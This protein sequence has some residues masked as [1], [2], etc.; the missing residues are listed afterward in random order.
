M[1]GISTRGGAVVVNTRSTGTLTVNQAI[2]TTPTT[3]GANG[4]FVVLESGGAISLAGS[5]TI[6]TSGANNAAGTGGNAGEVFIHHTTAAAGNI[7]LGADRKS[8][9]EG[10]SGDRG[11]RRNGT[12]RRLVERRGPKATPQCPRGSG[13]P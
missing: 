2:A 4:G 6:N 7:A 8:V 5:G 11:G 1:N 3:A 9:V 10:K 13:R 12:K